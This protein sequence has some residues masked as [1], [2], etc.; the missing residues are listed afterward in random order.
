MPIGTINAPM[1]ARYVSRERAAAPV[2]ANRE[3]ALLSNLF[4]HG[5]LL[6]LCQTNP[7]KE[8]RPNPEE[9]RT[10]APDSAVLERFL[11][12]VDTRSPQ[13][14]IIG[15]AAR[16]ASLAGC[17]QAE[18]LDLSWPQIDLQADVVRIK[19]AKQRGG[20][21]DHVVDAIG[22]GPDLAACIADLLASRKDADSLV[23]FASR[24]GNPYTARGFKTLW[25]R[26]VASAIAAQVIT[27]DQRFTFHDLR[28]HCVTA[29][30][31]RTGTLPDLHKNA[32]TTARVY[33][34]TTV[35]PRRPQ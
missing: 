33:D 1:V 20:K 13:R 2:R 25:Q 32:A 29:H 28:A 7:A 15:L 23:V 31:N 17:R 21:R 16:S 5:V 10:E 12:W 34:R 3:K 18:F 4:A 8:V 6:G 14:R 30:K 11:R 24:N 22:I 26:I 27:L 35:V 19:H 9:P